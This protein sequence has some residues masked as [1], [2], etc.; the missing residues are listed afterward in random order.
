MQNERAKIMTKTVKQRFKL[1][2]RIR[3][4]HGPKEQRDNFFGS[5]FGIHRVASSI[6]S[7]QQQI[8]SQEA[9]RFQDLSTSSNTFGSKAIDALLTARIILSGE[10]RKRP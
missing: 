2:K 9:Q 4:S 6:V 1:L 10:R 3:V 8:E 5:F 7:G